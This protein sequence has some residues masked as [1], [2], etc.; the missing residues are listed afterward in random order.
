MTDR[1]ILKGNTKL[2]RPI[3]TEVMALH[4]LLEAKDIGTIYAHH[5]DLESV[6]RVGK[7]KVNLYFLEDT[8]FNKRA[9]PNNRSEGVRRR[10]GLIRFRLM[11]ESTRT[12]SK[13]NATTLANKIKQVFGS[14]GGYVWNKG[15]T[16]YSYSDW[17]LGYQFQLLCRSETEAKRIVSSVL[18]LQNHTPDFKKFNQIKNDQEALTYPEN[19]GTEIVMGETVNIPKSRPL[20]DVRFQ[21]GYVKL[22]GVNEPINL[23][24]LKHNR[25]RELVT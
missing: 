11:D 16:M 18:S 4:Q 14:N 20:V 10:D 12:F 7:P 13:A 1:I 21:Y 24:S 5:N 2:L 19:P 22:D 8:N 6:K 23:Y 25:V 9:A 3:I 17:D 15:K